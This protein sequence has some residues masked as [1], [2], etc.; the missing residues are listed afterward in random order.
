VVG[1]ATSKALTYNIKNAHE[2][3]G[4][5]NEND[6][7]SCFKVRKDNISSLVAEYLFVGFMRW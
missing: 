3:L 2:L 7:G 4:H 6:V 1:E 5:N